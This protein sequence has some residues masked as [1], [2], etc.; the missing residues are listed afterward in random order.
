MATPPGAARSNR[1]KE[2]KYGEVKSDRERRASTRQR[3]QR[4]SS[5]GPCSRRKC[6]AE[7]AQ[8][9]VGVRMSEPI[10][11]L[12]GLSRELLLLLLPLLFLTGSLCTFAPLSSSPFLPTSIFACGCA[13]DLV[14]PNKRACMYEGVGAERRRSRRHGR[15]HRNAVR[16]GGSD[17]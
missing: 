12:S 17:R 14:S 6:P 8:Q 7:G 2:G 3:K 11:V 5:R 16:F 15:T 9:V 10:L 4:R 13:L 1:G